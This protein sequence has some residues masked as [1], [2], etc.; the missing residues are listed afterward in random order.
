MILK[1]KTGGGDF[2]VSLA[3]S[4]FKISL[5]LS[6]HFDDDDADHNDDYDG[7][8]CD[9]WDEKFGVIFL[10]TTQIL[11]G[12][13]L[14]HTD[15]RSVKKFDHHPSPDMIIVKCFTLAHFPKY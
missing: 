15:L 11:G 5:K 13:Q 9:A 8:H 6:G 2:E 1:G 3:E 10:D 14:Y 7:D 12:F 4:M